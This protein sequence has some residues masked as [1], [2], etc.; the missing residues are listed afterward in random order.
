VKRLYLRA[1]GK[2]SFAAPREGA[3]ATEYISDP[4]KPVPHA[5]RPVWGFNYG[6][7]SIISQWRC[8][9]VEDQRFADGRPDV[10]TWVS[11]SLQAPLTIRGPV[12]AKLFAET[13]GTDAD[14]VVKLIDVFPDEDP[15]SFEMSG[16]QLM[17]S[18]DIFR[19]RYR[20]D[21]AKAQALK[22]NEVLE[23]TMPLPTVNHTFKPGHRLMVQVQSTWFPLYDRN[24]QTFVDSI[25]DA[26]DS[27]YK[28]QKQRIHHSAASP[29][30]LELLVDSEN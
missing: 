19:G 8:W 12:L 28:A 5:P 4:A 2:L 21:Y 23:Y 14:W 17:I 30:H 7:P 16:F 9:L 6:V 26:P 18:A 10:A 13:T 20:E 1:N 27:S 25:M 11:E 22:A 29:T 15:G 24:P 3:G